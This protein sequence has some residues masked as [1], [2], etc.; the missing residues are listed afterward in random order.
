MEGMNAAQV[1]DLLYGPLSFA[2]PLV[3]RNPYGAY[4]G[5][6]TKAQAP[7]ERVQTL[8]DTKGAKALVTPKG[9]LFWAGAMVALFV[10]LNASARG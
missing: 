1:S 5:R 3:G 9:P 6:D 8:A 10:V 2:T 7:A 4:E